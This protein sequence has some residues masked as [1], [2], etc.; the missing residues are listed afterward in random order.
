MGDSLL[1]HD[2]EQIWASGKATSWAKERNV[3]TFIHSLRICCIIYYKRV[4]KKKLL[5]S[6]S[7]H[8]VLEDS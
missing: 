1:R 8:S 4:N 5:F 2:P 7:L 6:L 3:T